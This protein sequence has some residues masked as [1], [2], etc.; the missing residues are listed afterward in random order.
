MKRKYYLEMTEDKCSEGLERCT[1][2]KCGTEKAT[3]EAKYEAYDNLYFSLRLKRDRRVSMN[4][5][6][7]D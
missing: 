2:A 5:P 6:G 1:L 3:S 4:L 7:M